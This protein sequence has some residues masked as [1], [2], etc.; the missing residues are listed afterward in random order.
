MVEGR[1][2]LPGEAAR[3]HE[4][5]VVEQPQQIRGSHLKPVLGIDY[6]PEGS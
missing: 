5:L 1:Q 2:I 3:R 4:A 6:I